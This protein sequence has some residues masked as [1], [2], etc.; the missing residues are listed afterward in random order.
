M[1]YYSTE[2]KAE[3]AEKL[4][5][6]SDGVISTV[7][8]HRFKKELNTIRLKMAY[9][10]PTNYQIDDYFRNFLN[11]EVKG[12]YSRYDLEKQDDWDIFINDYHK[13]VDDIRDVLSKYNDTGYG[14]ENRNVRSGIILQLFYH[15]IFTE[16]LRE[17]KFYSEIENDL[18]KKNLDENNPSGRLLKEFKYKWEL[19]FPD[20]EFPFTE[21]EEQSAKQN[22]VLTPDTKPEAE[23]PT[24]TVIDNEG[25]VARVKVKE[26]SGKNRALKRRLNL[27]FNYDPNRLEDLISKSRHPKTKKF[28][29]RKLAKLLNCHHDTAKRIVD[30]SGLTHLTT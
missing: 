10:Y 11:N 8:E 18:I 15:T 21:I 13:N 3:N 12:F 4:F 25:R 1:K 17:K 16:I 20:R 14:G 7:Q 26:L 19:L 28:S 23:N 2:E 22:E 5:K 29:Y 27:K 24:E 6:A 9:L 30:Q